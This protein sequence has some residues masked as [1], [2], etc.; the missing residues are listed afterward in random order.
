[1]GERM[2]LV[3][4]LWLCQPGSSVRLPAVL[5]SPG[6]PKVLMMLPAREQGQG[7]GMGNVISELPVRENEA[8]NA[9]RFGTKLLAFNEGWGLATVVLSCRCTESWCCC[10]CPLG[11]SASLAGAKASPSTSPLSADEIADGLFAQD[12]LQRPRYQ[13]G[14]NEAGLQRR[15]N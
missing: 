2:K 1:M 9:K 6:L 11:A 10:T 14:I 15:A 12:G 13:S 7:H 5:P 8:N 3:G 4:G